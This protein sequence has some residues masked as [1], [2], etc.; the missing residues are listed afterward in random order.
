T[1]PPAARTSARTASA[2]A[3]ERVGVPRRP[4][5]K[6]NSA[7][8][9]RAATTTPTKR[10]KATVTNVTTSSRFTGADRTVEKGPVRRAGERSYTRNF[11]FCPKSPTYIGQ[12]LKS[13]VVL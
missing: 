13:P 2:A 8:R 7:A 11:F 3:S 6:A 5:R 9:R 12:G 4:K 10:N 1:S